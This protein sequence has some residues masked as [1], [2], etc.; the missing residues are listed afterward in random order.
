MIWPQALSLWPLLSV[1]AAQAGW[2]ARVA[3]GTALSAGE[4]MQLMTGRGELAHWLTGAPVPA[5]QLRAA[6]V[7]VLYPPLDALAHSIGGLAATRALSLLFMLTATVALWFVTFRLTGRRGAFLACATW[8][9]LTPAAHLGAA[10]T[11]DAASVCLLALALWSV[12]RAGPGQDETGWMLLA[13]GALILGNAIAYVSVVGDPVVLGLAILTA[14]PVPGGKYAVMRGM[15]L[16]AYATTAVILLLTADGSYELGIRR[17]L[18]AMLAGHGALLAAGPA[19]AWELAWLVAGVVAL[20]GC[21]ALRL[22]SHRQ[23]LLALLLCGG[24][25]LPLAQVG[26]LVGPD[27]AALAGLGSWLGAAAAACTVETVIASF[28]FRPA[29]LA[30]GSLGLILLAIP[31]SLGGVR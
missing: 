24:A 25:L 16:L 1:L 26:F 18:A 7:P 8:V 12:S 15:S 20:A 11:A 17:T 22:P 27:V 4:G 2:S 31:V 10:A 9:A 14:R 30:V 13:A 29:R 6:G 5:F 19:R 21:A 3:G 23:L 28:R